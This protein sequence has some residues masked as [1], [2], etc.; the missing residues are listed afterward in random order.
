MLVL[1]AAALALVVGVVIFLREEHSDGGTKGGAVSTPSTALRPSKSGPG[2]PARPPEKKA[3]APNLAGL[4]GGDLF[5]VKPSLEDVRKFLAAQGETPANLVAAFEA[6]NDEP[7]LI[8]AEELHPNSPIVLLALLSKGGS[9]EKKAGWI[10]RLKAA[11][12]NNP[13]PWIYAAQQQFD[14]KNPEEAVEALRS[15]LSRPGFYAYVNERTAAMNALF[16]S[17]G[18]DPM[19]ADVRSIFGITLFQFE[20]LKTSKGLMELQKAASETGETQRAEEL[21]QLM[22]GLAKMYRSP[23]ASRFLIGQLVAMSVE[24]RALQA[25]PKDQILPSGGTVG[26]RLEAVGKEKQEIGS[27]TGKTEAWLA[28]RP[29]AVP[30]YFRRVKQDGEFS[31]LRWLKSRQ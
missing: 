10:E 19:A 9:A 25:M 6:T 31:A 22:Y 14:S 21:G 29:D 28:N 7:W 8:R 24:V 20:N 1:L 15:G 13:I 4:L 5:T 30:E 2:A 11:D 16:A 17:T 23:E 12:P 18:M 3:A 27:L 26:E